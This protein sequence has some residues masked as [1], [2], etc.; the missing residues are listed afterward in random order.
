MFI[1]ILVALI[2]FLRTRVKSDEQ[3]AYNTDENDIYVTYERGWDG[4]DDYGNGDVVEVV[5]VNHLYGH[6]ID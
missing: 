2:C 5:D 6:V 1:I 4:E 3:P